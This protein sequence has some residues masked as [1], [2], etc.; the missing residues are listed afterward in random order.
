MHGY[1]V[2]STNQKVVDSAESVSHSI[3]CQSVESNYNTLLSTAQTKVKSLSG[4]IIKCKA[5]IDNAS[6][7]S[8]ISRKIAEKLN[9]PLVSTS[10]KLVG[11]NGVSA[12]TYLNS[13]KLQFLPHFSNE[14]KV[15]NAL[16]VSQVTNPLP[17]FRLVK[18]SWPHI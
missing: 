9:L 12:E 17:N 8:L 11:I 10:H 15:L 16:V 18:S 3:Q 14:Y 13:T 2:N 4:K 1:N 5:L 6:Q 7:N